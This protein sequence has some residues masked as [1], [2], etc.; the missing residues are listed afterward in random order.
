MSPIDIYFRLF[1]CLGEFRGALSLLSYIFNGV[2]SN[3]D[4]RKFVGFYENCLLTK[5]IENGK[6][7]DVI[8]YLWNLFVK[9]HLL[10]DPTCFKYVRTFIDAN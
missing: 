2:F 6:V 7:M 1:Q 5:I 3:E 4:Y 8:Y 10:Y 9:F